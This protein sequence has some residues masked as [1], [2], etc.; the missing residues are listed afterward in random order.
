MPHPLQSEAILAGLLLSH[1]INQ[2]ISRRLVILKKE[3]SLEHHWLTRY[4]IVGEWQCE[5]IISYW[6]L[7]FKRR[8]ILPRNA[9]VFHSSPVLISP[10]Y[11]WCTGKHNVDLFLNIT[12]L[13][14]RRPWFSFVK[15]TSKACHTGLQAVFFDKLFKHECSPKYNINLNSFFRK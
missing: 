3:L 15:I 13:R 6:P 8:I 1:T 14:L 7:E 12:Y 5:D 4:K 10:H 11:I 9:A 2:I